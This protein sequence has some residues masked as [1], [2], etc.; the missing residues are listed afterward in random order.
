MPKT[1]GNKSNKK[2]VN[3]EAE[4]PDIIPDEKQAIVEAEKPEI[5]PDEKQAE[6]K[7]DEKQAKTELKKPDIIPDEK[8]TEPEIFFDKEIVPQKVQY[9]II[10]CHF[11]QSGKCTKGENCPFKHGAKQTCLF[12]NTPNGCRNGEKCPFSH[13]IKETQDKKVIPEQEKDGKERRY[14]PGPSNY[15]TRLCRTVKNGEVCRYGVECCF[16]H[17]EKEL[18]FL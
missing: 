12:I 5:I 7:P 8:Q 13:D 16:A 18:R 9:R 3:I 6:V 1:K 14:K 4:K 11:Y 2:Q 15:K 17:G 10:N